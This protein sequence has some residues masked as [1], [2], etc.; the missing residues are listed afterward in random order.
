MP[1][2]RPLKFKTPEDLQAQIDGYF[3]Q[4]D[5]NPRMVYTV[6]GL[7]RALEIDTDTLLNYE[8][9]DNF[10][11]LIKGAKQRIAEFW[12][13]R[14]A[15]TTPT[16]A[17]F[18]LKNAG[19]KDRQEVENKKTFDVTGLEDLDD[20]ELEGLIKGLQNRAG[21]GTPGEEA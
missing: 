4:A 12:E 6:N 20:D 16:G 15:G 11:V 9:R 1:A 17:I 2:G 19:W 3:G 8:K 21:N 13:S 14:L 5:Q 10:S 18:W 7:A